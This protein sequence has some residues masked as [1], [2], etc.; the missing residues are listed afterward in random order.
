MSYEQKPP[1]FNL[2]R[3]DGI[4]GFSV[5][6]GFLLSI[7]IHTGL[8]ISETGVALTILKAISDAFGSKYAYLITIISVIAGI[9]EAIVM[10][11]CILQISQRGISGI[12]V[13]GCGFFGTLS[14]ILGSLANVSPFV[15]L[16]VA[17]WFA[18]I[19]VSRLSD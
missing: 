7:L 10:A 9:A 5:F 11:F 2:K 18:G 15:Y 12:I 13:A 6:S 19:I 3:L 8:D 4:F 14:A 17:M 16:G 1:N